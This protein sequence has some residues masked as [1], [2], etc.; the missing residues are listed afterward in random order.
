[1]LTRR[2]FVASAALLAVSGW[3]GH[4]LISP[5]AAQSADRGAAEFI[6]KLG[7]EA[8]ATFS[9]KSLSRDQAIQRFRKLLYAGFDVPYIGRWVLGR[10]WN[11]ATEAQRAEYQ[12]LFE[13]LIVNTYAERFVEYSGETFKII[14]TSPAGES[15]TMVTTQIVRPNG[16]PVNV[17]WRVRKVGSD[18]KIIDVVVEN[19]SM[20]VTQRQEFASV[21]EQNGGRVEGLIQ[22]LRQKVGARAG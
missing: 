16:P 3:A 7:N 11:S 19:V 17:S 1:M 13:Q 21:I 12:K 6:Q 20:G 9:D 8:I 4:L 5:A 18:F 2:K 22:A 14:G 15:D 10:Y